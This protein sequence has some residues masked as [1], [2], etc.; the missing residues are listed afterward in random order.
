MKY[1]LVLAFLFMAFFAVC[2]AEQDSASLQLQ[3]GDVRYVELE[4]RPESA[5]KLSIYFTNK[6]LLEAQTLIS[7]NLNQPIS[8]FMN[9]KLV[10]APRIKEPL[11][12]KNRFLSLRF[13][14]FDSAVLAARLLV[15]TQ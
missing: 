13:P 7:K 2:H 5:P 4:L 11:I 6:K 14:D 9:G 15:P 8:I 3:K 10:V 1:N 12:Y